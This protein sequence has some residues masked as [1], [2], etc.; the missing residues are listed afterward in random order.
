MEEGH[1]SSWPL[2]KQK[3]LSFRI[4]VYLRCRL[5]MAAE[6]VNTVSSELHIVV[7]HV[8]HVQRLAIG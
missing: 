8:Y 1:I 7:C 4:A 3:E 2:S 5:E 6:E